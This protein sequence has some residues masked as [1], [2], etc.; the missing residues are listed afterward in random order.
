MRSAC[1]EKR[2]TQ[3]TIESI[4]DRHTFIL[5]DIA[6]G[7][8]ANTPPLALGAQTKTTFPPCY[9]MIPTTSS[10]DSWKFFKTL[11][12]RPRGP[13]T[14]TMVKPS[15]VRTQKNGK[16]CPLSPR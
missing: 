4:G 5:M 1:V 3:L 8:K 2:G 12:T 9:K 7:L 16:K 6:D 10:I 15:G 13:S 14:L 11:A